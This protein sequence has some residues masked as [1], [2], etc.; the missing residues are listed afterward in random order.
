MT[1]NDIISEL[2]SK[3]YD[4][5]SVL[6]KVKVIAFKTWNED[7]SKWVDRELNWYDDL[8]SVPEY[9]KT[10]C[11]I[12]WIVSN[13]HYYQQNITLPIVHLDKSIRELLTSAV[14]K[15]PISELISLTDRDN[16]SLHTSI[17]PNFFHYIDKVYTNW[18]HVQSA[19]WVLP[20]SIIGWILGVVWSKLLDF[21]LE[22]SKIVDSDTDIV[23]LTIV[24]KN[25]VS[26]IK[27]M[28][29]QIFHWPVHMSWVNQV[30]SSG[31]ITINYA[32][33]LKNKGIHEDD[34]EELKEIAKIKN[35]TEKQKQKEWWMKKV[36]TY[37]PAITIM[38]DFID[39]AL[40]AFI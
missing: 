17:D 28:A 15:E 35:E 21:L 37:L 34:I 23:K 30:G 32:E 13:G 40:E 11:S 4:I 31:N 9:R 24:E 38:V 1:I 20:I 14:F 2:V 3:N 8:E 19:H 33:E 5:T 12:E 27:T 39:T 10:H 26:D 16:D 7:L 29:Q 36:W 22:L 6:R 18:Y 25:Q